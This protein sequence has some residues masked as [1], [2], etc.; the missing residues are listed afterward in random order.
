M[1]YR[2]K[3]QLPF[4]LEEIDIR[5]SGELFARYRYQIPVIEIEGVERL[6]L[7]FTYEQLLQVL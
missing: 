1:L 2:A 4:E 6:T 5:S 3:K 7:K